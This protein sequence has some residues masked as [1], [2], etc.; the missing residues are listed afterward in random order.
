MANVHRCVRG[1]TS[2]VIFAPAYF[3]PVPVAGSVLSDPKRAMHTSLAKVLALSIS[4]AGIFLLESW[5]G[6]RFPGFP[7]RTPQCLDG[8]WRHAT[9][10]DTTESD[11]TAVAQADTAKVLVPD[12]TLAGPADST[13]QYILLTGDSMIEELQRFLQPIAKR[14]GHRMSTAIWYGSNCQ[15]WA[16]S[17]RLREILAQYRPSAVIFSSGA[18]EILFNDPP[19][20]KVFVDS[21]RAVFDQAGIPWLWIGPPKWKKGFGIDDTIRSVVGDSRYFGIGMHRLARKK[22][23]AHPTREAAGIWADS[24]CRW[25]RTQPNLFGRHVVW[26]TLQRDTLGQ[27]LA[28]EKPDRSR[29]AGFAET[30]ILPKTGPLE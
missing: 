10:A 5:I 21:I 19:K 29:W 11:T 25:I 18:N 6:H 28:P 14:N 7:L 20:R 9:P 23:G 13:G 2:G 16:T 24:L 22:D 15:T 27:I 26:D 4:L 30:R 17:G 3:D 8:I 1:S 12:S